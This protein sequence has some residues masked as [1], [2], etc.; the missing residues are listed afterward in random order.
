MQLLEVEHLSVSYGV[1]KAVR[2]VSF[3]VDAAATTTIIG[4]N[5]AGKSTIMKAIA[6]LIKPDSGSIRMN[7]VELA[8]APCYEV[9]AHG[10][11]LAPEGRQIFPRFTVMD[12]LII[13]AHTRSAKDKKEGI[14]QA[15]ALFPILKERANQLGG[16][17]S[18]GEQQMLAVARALMA[19]P[20]LLILDEPSLGLAPLVVQELFALFTHINQ[21]GIAI[22][23]VEQNARM[24]LSVSRRGYVLETG[25]I[26]LSD[27]G[28]ALRNNQTV[29]EAYLGGL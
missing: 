7:G 17:L 8:G 1:V 23:L 10:I 3:Q 6:G 19:K 18:G 4:S 12:N 16:T 22:L 14:E 27:T 21:E 2:D 29:R 11:T 13:G 26:I 25:Q 24:A 9:V 20:K 28:E 5:G 15:F